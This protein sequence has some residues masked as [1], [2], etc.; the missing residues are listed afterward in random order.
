MTPV[1]RDISFSLVVAVV[2]VVVVVVVYGLVYSR[3]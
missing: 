3:E 1:E 2:V